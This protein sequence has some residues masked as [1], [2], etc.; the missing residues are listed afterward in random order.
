MYT[1]TSASL[2]SFPLYSTHPFCPIPDADDHADAAA[3]PIAVI[4]HPGPT[5]RSRCVDRSTAAVALARR[6]P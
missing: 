5:S 4:T 2:H 1:V 3:M 6:Q